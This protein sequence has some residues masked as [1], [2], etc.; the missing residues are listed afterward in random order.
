MDKF[1]ATLEKAWHNIPESMLESLV[2]SIPR[3]VNAVI[4]A[5]G[6]YTKY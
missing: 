6:W 5:K 2:R 4:K 3:R 1:Y